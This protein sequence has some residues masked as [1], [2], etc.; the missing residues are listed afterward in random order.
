MC[1][2]PQAEGVLL[3]AFDD[4]EPRTWPAVGDMPKDALRTHS[5][6]QGPLWGGLIICI[7]LFALVRQY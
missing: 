1:C 6:E 3:R 4:P 2:L 5:A 7:V